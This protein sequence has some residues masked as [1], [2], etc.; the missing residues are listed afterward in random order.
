M[1]GRVDRKREKVG[2][3]PSTKETIILEKYVTE[4]DAYQIKMLI[5]LA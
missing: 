4:S 3:L 2:S 1:E 5:F